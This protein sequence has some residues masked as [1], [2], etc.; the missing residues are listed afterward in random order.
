MSDV[1]IVG[2]G[3]AGLS[4]ALRLQEAGVDFVVVEAA[5]AVGG[6]VR[7]DAHNGF[8]LDRGFQ[9]LIT[10]YPEA[11]RVLDYGGLD[12]HYFDAGCVVYRNG[13][14]HPF[15]DPW[16]HPSSAISSLFAP[17]GSFFDRVR[18]A[19][20]RSRVTSPSLE[21]LLGRP[22]VPTREALTREGFSHEMQE[23]F[24]KPFLAGVFLE[25]DLVTSSRKFQW[26]FRMFSKGRAAL[27]GKGIGSI[28]AQ[29]A[30]RLPPDRI[31]LG[32]RVER[33]SEGCV[34]LAD[35]RTLLCPQTVVATDAGTAIGLIDGLPR[36][37]FRGVTTLYYSLDEAPIKGPS[38]LLNG[39]GSGV[40]NNLAFV[41]EVSPH[42][43]PRDRALASVSVVVRPPDDDRTLDDM[44][45]RQLVEWFGMR[46]G[47]WRL[48]RVYRI[49]HALP[50]QSS[51]RLDEVRRA[52]RLQDWLV[53]AGD[54]RNIASING[55]MESG[56]LAAEAVLE[57]VLH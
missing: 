9:V 1:V 16:R 24:F 14:F 25:S 35:G 19:R 13:G 26:V 4:C 56:R 3:L 46:V 10:A 39:E 27:P 22:E 37:E 30:S 20:L 17:F 31:I 11:A 47:D 18:V 55:A 42:Y 15:F 53:V 50:D 40:V 7:T 6:R 33:V 49:E 12:L 5:D 45:R 48:E 34:R 36:Q 41:S 44:V 28:P 29:I 2:A 54:W 8:L 57:K 51:G 38:L 23:A 32:A 52:A 43:A 21:T